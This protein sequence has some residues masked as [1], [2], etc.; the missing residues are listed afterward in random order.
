MY[1][2]GNINN[3]SIK[4]L[5]PN[6][7][8][9]YA[10]SLCKKVTGFDEVYVNNNG[11]LIFQND[12]EVAISKI[13]QKDRTYFICSLNTN[14]GVKMV[15]VHTL[16]NIAY[17]G[18]NLK[19]KV[20]HLD[21]NQRNNHFTN[22]RG[23][24]NKE[25]NK[26]LVERSFYN[27]RGYN[28][29]IPKSDTD[30]VKRMLLDGKSLKYIADLYGCSDMSIVRFKQKHFK[31]DI[32]RSINKAN[33]INTDH[34]PDHIVCAI[35]EELKQGKRQIDLSHKYN[36]SPTVVCRINRKYIKKLK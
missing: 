24:S 31:R 8:T 19:N 26:Y 15:Y 27:S 21:N 5:W 29:S 36:V 32:I 18:G 7:M 2:D 17:N 30:K 4:N 12:F 6:K 35:V 14:R 34:T 11:T 25:F 1:L 10:K 3:T 13:E 33:G 20:I 16:V 22:L 23:L 28:T 9:A